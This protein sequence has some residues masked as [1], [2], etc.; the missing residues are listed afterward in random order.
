MAACITIL[1]TQHPTGTP[2]WLRAVGLVQPSHPY[3]FHA[4][5]TSSL[6]ADFTGAVRRQGLIVDMSAESTANRM[7]PMLE[8]ANIPIWY[9]FPYG[10]N[11]RTQFGRRLKAI[12]VARAHLCSIDPEAWYVPVGFD[13]PDNVKDARPIYLGYS[14]QPV[15]HLY[16]SVT[17]STKPPPPESSPETSAGGTII[18]YTTDRK[19]RRPTSPLP[20]THGEGVYGE[21]EFTNGNPAEPDMSPPTTPPASSPNRKRTK[22]EGEFDRFID[23]EDHE[24]GVVSEPFVHTGQH[25]GETILNY[26]RRRANEDHS[27]A[28]E[29][30]S[31][32]KHQF[33]QRTQSSSG[34][35]GQR[36]N[37]ASRLYIW[38]PIP[39]YPHH[40]RL[41]ITKGKALENFLN[42]SPT[43]RIYHARS[44]T[45]DCCF[46]LDP[47][48]SNVD[49]DWDDED[50]DIMERDHT[51]ATHCLHG[52]GPNR[53]PLE[54]PPLPRTELERT[55]F[56]ASDLDSIEDVLHNRYGIIETEGTWAGDHVEADREKEV[57]N[58]LRPL[59]ERD[60]MTARLL[61][62]T[63]LVYSLVQLVDQIRSRGDFSPH[64]SCAKQNL[65]ALTQAYPDSLVKCISHKLKH[66]PIVYVLQAVDYLDGPWTIAVHDILTV[67]Q[68]LRSQW[69]PTSGTIADKLLQR[70][71]PYT[72]LWR[73]S[74]QFIQVERCPTIPP[75]YRPSSYTWHADDYIGYSMCRTKYLQNP[76][77]ANSA[78]RKGGILWRLAIESGVSLQQVA[79]DTSRQ[80]VLGPRKIEVGDELLVTE[81]LPAATSD[82]IIGLCKTYTGEIRYFTCQS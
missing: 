43:Q 62:Q 34:R 50:E 27:K 82:M 58:R 13:G 60:G 78:L 55:V 41:R 26:I 33:S 54:D 44:D 81:D 10:T 70:G 47:Q 39:E 6:V 19:R 51:D 45:W 71:I 21:L 35:F 72:A 38:K 74:A 30:T 17:S 8:D 32:Q 79:F 53:R 46:E 31:E 37:A 52:G 77:I 68:V 12:V 76:A 11:P 69:G 56:R 48:G 1:S 80:P 64:L 63:Q 61:G 59:V 18:S 57:K 24:C 14:D 15:H 42:Y 20:A 22:R 65:S 5:T 3:W 2:T 40:I 75:L 67:G 29:D 28:K 16:H 73:D 7:L 66:G 49:Q 36:L 9:W 4:F 23:Q 25:E